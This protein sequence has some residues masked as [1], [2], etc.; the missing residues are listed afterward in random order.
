MKAG[1]DYIGVGVG[2]LV[3]NHK[4]EVFLAKRGQ[5]ATNERGLWEFPGGQVEYGEKLVEAITREFFEEYGMEIEAHDS[6]GAFDHILPEEQQHWV[7]VTFIAKQMAGTPHIREPEKCE[8][9]GW[10]SLSALPAP[11]TKV[12]ED[13]LRYYL[14]KYDT[15][16]F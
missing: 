6:L 12:T 15:D 3:F 5:H 7:S 1:Y 9:I 4:G 2:A 8:D 14:E 11:L 10:F 16:E 13:N